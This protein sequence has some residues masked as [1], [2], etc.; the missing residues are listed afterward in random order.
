MSDGEKRRREERRRGAV[1]FRFACAHQEGRFV[2][3][4]RQL[5]AVGRSAGRSGCGLPSFPSGENFPLSEWTETWPEAEVAEGTNERRDGKVKR[6]RGRTQHGAAA[7]KVRWMQLSDKFATA[8]FT[9]RLPSSLPP[10]CQSLSLHTL[11]ARP[12]VS[13]LLM[14]PSGTAARA[15]VHL[16][17]EGRKDGGKEGWRKVKAE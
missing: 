16:E 1:T 15:A 11:P 2:R 12:P 6:E 17:M 5:A 8:A 3:E 7:D 13:P 14:P 9:C 4:E 10:Q